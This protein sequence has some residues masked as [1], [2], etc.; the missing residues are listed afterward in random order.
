MKSSQTS[1]IGTLAFWALFMFI[2]GFFNAI[3]FIGGAIGGA[4][5][6]ALAYGALSFLPEDDNGRKLPI[7]ASLPILILGIVILVLSFVMR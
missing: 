7:W 3:H 1:E 5:A 2:F 6:G 4:L